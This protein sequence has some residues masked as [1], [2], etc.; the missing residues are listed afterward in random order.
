MSVALHLVVVLDD[1][2]YDE[3]QDALDEVVEVLVDHGATGTVLDLR[4]G[5]SNKAGYLLDDTG[6]DIPVR[7]EKVGVERRLD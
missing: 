4:T 3:D 1:D 6:S 2:R 5:E 7:I